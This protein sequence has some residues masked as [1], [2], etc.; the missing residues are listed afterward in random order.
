M[1]RGFQSE[2]VWSEAKVEELRELWASGI[3]AGEIAKQLGCGISRNAVIGKAH[4]LKL[5]RRVERQATAPRQYPTQ[6]RKRVT[7]RLVLPDWPPRPPKPPAPP[8]EP[9]R[10]RPHLLTLFELRSDSCRW[11]IEL[12]DPKTYWE[13]TTHFCGARALE[14]SPYCDM[15]DRKA[16]HKPRSGG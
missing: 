11:P 16:Y 6:R 3:S 7:P 8:P 12:D 15:H 2:S 9:P 10:P 1:P 5:E 13:P 4:R 14:N